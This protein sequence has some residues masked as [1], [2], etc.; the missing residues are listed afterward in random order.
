MKKIFI[1]I[2]VAVIGAAAY[3]SQQQDANYNVLNYVPADTPIFA[4]QLTPFPIKDYIN[5]GAHLITPADQ[6]KLD[7]L[8]DASAKD[9]PA[10]H[11][12]TSLLKTYQAS[13]KDADLLVK[14]FGLADNV[15]AYFYTLGLLPVLKIEVADPQ[16][17]WTLLDKKELETGFSHTEEKIQD[18]TYRSY[19]ISQPDATTKV[20]LVVAQADGILTLTINTD[21]VSNNLLATALGLNKPD[22]SLADTNTL[23]DIIQQHSFS[24]ASVGFINHI[25]II[26]GLTTTNGN[27]LAEQLTTIAKQ[28]NS[29][30]LAQLHTATC[31]SEMASIAQNWPRTVFGYTKI[32][33]TQE[34]ST[35]A[36]ATIIESKNKVILDAL[37]AMRGF[38]P[39]YTQ[40]FDKNVIATSLGL[41]VSQLSTSLTSIWKDL[42]T[43]T[44]QCAPLAEIQSKISQSGQSLA[45]LGLGSNMAASVKGISAGIFDYAVSKIDE[46]PQLDNVD[47]LVAIHTDNPE[48]IF[49]S[50]KMF[51]PELQNVQ[52]VNNGPAVSLNKIY[53]IPEKLHLDPKLAIKGQHLVIYNGNKGQQEAEKLSLEKLSAIGLY[54]ASFD[55]KK[56]LSPIINAAAIAG[57]V[58]PEEAMFLMEY[59]AGMNINLDVNDQGIRFDTIANHESPQKNN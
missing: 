33:I 35:V 6:D 10:F 18:L 28:D 46:Q 27:Q 24:D 12:L 13:A 38:I 41:D 29:D 43:P 2:A 56:M 16:A 8:Y 11:F 53:P 34:H 36:F 59:N 15:R 1:P 47:A 42:Q 20:E 39:N 25:E 5:S 3:F 19:E 48:M 22:T 52:L 23:Q 45:M 14:T 54:Q 44:Y 37:K 7:A 17:I 58:I 57:D 40:E 31:Q 9:S 49:N 21:I 51:S 30:P 50:I 55:A 4:G 32:D 26:K